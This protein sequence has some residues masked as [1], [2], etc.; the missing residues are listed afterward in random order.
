MLSNERR[1]KNDVTFH[2][3]EVNLA[4]AMM[5]KSRTT[6]EFLYYLM[7]HRGKMSFTLILLSTNN[8]KLEHLLQKWKRQTDILLEIDY[9]N[10]LYMIICQSTDRKGGQ[11]FAE[12][13]MTNIHMNGGSDSYCVESELRSTEHT[14]QE[15]IFTMV[16]KYIYI[17][18]EKKAN[19]VFFTDLKYEESS[20][21]NS[22]ILYK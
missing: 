17:K 15:V 4:K 11:E 14:I 6:M 12:I 22:D 20:A 16:E 19:K 18:Q 2:E 10:N 1:N 5:D 9:A 13:L 21:Y 7:N 3:D 8:L